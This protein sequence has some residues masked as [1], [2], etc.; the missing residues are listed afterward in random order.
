MIVYAEL[1]NMV[2]ID[3]SLKFDRLFNMNRVDIATF[4]LGVS[5]GEHIRGTN[6]QSTSPFDDL[7]HW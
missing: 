1:D 3:R 7:L 4:T 2:E 6:S 5:L